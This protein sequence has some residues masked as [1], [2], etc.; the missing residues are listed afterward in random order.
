MEAIKEAPQED[1]QPRLYQSQMKDICIAKNTIIYLPT[2]AGKTHIALMAIKELGRLGHLDKPLTQGGKR[3]FFIVNTVALAKQQAEMI[4]RNVAFK[5]S[6]YTSDRNVD[7]WKQNRWLDEFAKYQIIVCTCQILLD[8]L[9][10]GY[11]SMKHINLLVFDECHHGVGDHPMHGIM[12]QYLTAR[13]EDR[14]RVIGLSGMLLYK[15]LKMKDQVRQELERLE[16]TFDST[17]A[18]VGSY[19]EYTEVCKFSTDPRESLLPFDGVPVSDVMRSLQTQ[20]QAFIDKVALFDLPKLLNQNKALLRDLPKPKKV[21]MK[22]FKELEYQM[23]DLGLFGAAIALLGLIVQFELD[24]RE[25]DHTM[26]RLL[27]RSCITFCEN[28]RHQLENVMQGLEMK[29]K[30]TLFSSFKARQL[31]AQL[32]RYYSAGRS[33]KTK[34][35]IFVQRRFSAKVV[36]HLLKIYFS[37][38]ED[39][40]TIVPDFMVGSNG[41]MPESIE[42]I[43]SAK[44]DRRVL[45]RFKKN[46]TNVIVTTN[47]LEE[48]IDL[49]MCN[50]V[51]KFDHPETFASYEQSKGRARM[52]DSTYTVMLKTDNREKFLT[53]YRLYKEIEEE[54]KRALV[55]KT[56]N[57]PEPLESDVTKELTNELIPPFYTKKGAKLDALSSIQLLNRYCMGMPR[58]AFTNT[59][60]T[61]ERKELSSGHILVAVLLPL[62]STVREKVFGKPMKNVKLAKRS[63]AFEAC[64]L[65]YEAGELN[66]HL[67]PVDAKR[68]LANVSEIYFRHWKQFEDES[69]KQ[70]GTQKNVRNHQI[71]YP[72]QT[73]G[74]CPQPG[75]PC[76]IYVL[77]IAAGFKSDA[78]NENI[79]TFHK[80][81]SSE[82]NFGLMTTKPLPVLA[83]MKFFVSLG[84][85][86]AHLDST[87]I[88]LESAGSEADLAAL[89][90]FQLMLFRDVLRL[91]KEFL[92]LDNS[93]EA[94][95]LLV[96]PLAQSRQID[97][98]VVKDFPFLAQP[99]EL[100]TIARSRM[101]FDA[102]QYRHRVILPWYRTDRERAY[103]VTA[104]HEHLTPDSPFPNEKYQSYADY[105]GTV[106]GQHVVN[107]EQFLIEV[108]GVTTWLNRLSPGDDDD[109][110]SAT[111][112]KNW[113]FHEILIPELCHNFAFPADY[114]LKA[115]LLPSALH[116]L[117]YLLLAENIRVEL[118]TEANVGCLECRTVEDVD[119]EYKNRKSTDL[120]EGMDELTFDDDED[121]DDEDE[122]DFDYEDAKHALGGPEDLNSLMRSQLNSFAEEVE[123]PWKEQDEPADIERNWDKVTALD[124]DYYDTF[125]RKFASLNVGEQIT[126]QMAQ[127]YSSVIHKRATVG[128]PEKVVGAILDVPLEEKFRIELLKLTPENTV[129]VPLQQRAIIKALT[130]KSS[131]DVYDLERYELLGDAF[132]KFSVSLFLVK[133][134][135]D[136]HEGHLTA[137]KGQLVSNRNLLYCAMLVSLPGMMK[138]HTFDPKNDWTPPLATVP[139]AVKAKMASINHSARILYRLKM[140]EEEIQSGTIEKE[141][142]EDFIAELDV[143]SQSL[144][145]SPM[146]NY[147]SQQAMGDKIPADAMEAMLGVCVSTVGIKRSFRLLTF[148]G[149]LPK[150]ENLMTLLD[151][152]IANQRLKAD[153]SKHEV[154][155]FLISPGRIERILNYTF[156]DRTYLLQAL[157]HASYPT[158]R[159]TGSYQQL[160]FVGD[161]VL[162]FLI[163]AYIYEQNPTMS[164]GQLTDLRS[165]LVNNITL[166]CILVRHGLHLYILSESASLSDTVNKFVA[167]QENHKHEITDQVNLLAEESE[168]GGHGA[169]AEFVDVPKA[170]GDVFESLVGAVFL[171]SGND[172]DATWRV[173]YGLMH[174]E[175]ATF[176]VDTPI[177]IV[178]RLHEWKPPCYPKF[179]RAIVDDDTVLVKLRYRIR[180]VEHE[181]YGFGQNKEDAKRAAAKVALQK[182]RKQ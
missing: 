31:I 50:S 116:R 111:R 140:S 74:C 37:Q 143:Q 150:K 94:N 20:I 124:L 17:I 156:K 93:N 167:F 117:N 91:W 86:D 13:K 28:L 59:N 176:S 145:T 130:T 64:R 16:N 95:S 51:I 11:L 120:A 54:L 179:S 160:E 121:E 60:V 147:L 129:H 154:D 57:R 136:W 164:P 113:T 92:V 90:Q 18:T 71:Q 23:G 110:K 32:E 3:T 63:A 157:T 89:K 6:V 169:M 87:P 12:E 126:T 35:L 14:P 49:Q 146:Q 173:I 101:V 109:G 88:R 103:V 46:E 168:R 128:S 125:V 118:A 27:Y 5:T 30:L 180:N 166:A 105:F 181:A 66:E 78:L 36:Y 122:D 56:I 10:H 22:Y 151:D 102:Q 65:L 62:Q 84:L 53:K 139:H 47:V 170:L 8:V 61:W 149:I 133:K 138:I 97:W 19:D 108:K 100:P 41:S 2:G 162:D 43:L 114:W 112:S 82:N 34:T 25:S 67:I 83:R 42:Q 175:I 99:S 15:E 152:R 106:Y 127:S 44:K 40:E 24:K 161:A 80:L 96:V 158:N 141:K 153:V 7:T 177:Q 155:S 72:V 77:R 131:H 69:P 48:G 104:V 81:Y 4:G 9:K 45:E 75:M 39:A 68:Q 148:L 119:V 135:K 178:R 26:L 163:S 29:K 165:A 1:F 98:Q 55:G 38:T 137:V 172:L 174:R 70:A 171:D 132:L 182:L 58:D 107:K 76:Y 73:T 134:H 142:Y 144:D 79:E 21:I 115:T 123:M 33:R 52:K 159:I 85:I